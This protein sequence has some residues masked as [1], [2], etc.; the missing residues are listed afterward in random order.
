MPRGPAPA[1]AYRTSRLIRAICAAGE[2]RIPLGELVDKGFRATHVYMDLGVSSMQIDTPERGFS[3]NYDAPLDMRMDPTAPVTA[4]DIVNTWSEAALADQRVEQE[5]AAGEGHGPG[6]GP[7]QGPGG[8]G[9][10]VPG[11]R[12]RQSML[13]RVACS[14]ETIS[15]DAKTP[16]SG[17]RLA[18]VNPQQSQ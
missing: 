9:G 2:I 13:S 14:T 16:M 3:Y 11:S 8:G 5:P 18:V 1:G 15:F 7:G 17:T 4:A 12:L 6:I 10:T